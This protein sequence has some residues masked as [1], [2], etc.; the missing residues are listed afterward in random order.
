MRVCVLCPF[1]SSTR[2]FMSF[3][4][5]TEAGWPKDMPREALLP[6]VAEVVERRKE[7]KQK[8]RKAFVD[9][10]A[11]VLQAMRLTSR[12]RKPGWRTVKEKLR[13]QSC[14]RDIVSETERFDLYEE[15]LDVSG[16]WHAPSSRQADASPPRGRYR[17][18]P[19][20][21]REDRTTS[22]KRPRVGKQQL[23][24]VLKDQAKQDL[25]ML[26][27]E[28]LKNPFTLTGQAALESLRSDPRYEPINKELRFPE[29]LQVYREFVQTLEKERLD[30]FERELSQSPNIPGPQVTFEQASEIMGWKLDKR[31][32]GLSQEAIETRFTKWR[33]TELEECKHAFCAFL[34]ASPS[35]S[36]QVPERGPEFRELMQ[37]LSTDERYR[38]LDG[39]P[40][41][42]EQLVIERLRELQ[43]ES[44]KLGLMRV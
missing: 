12:D 8:Q 5:G 3:R 26:L 43:K 20:P 6:L 10:A 23:L 1:H 29:Q 41:I 25:T 13:E 14:Y 19:S 37:E 15:A 16:I 34:Q 36:A 4:Y 21:R 33:R 35:V 9:A 2:H 11:Q 7:E 27:T 40:A 22:P 28:R 17:R 31:F 32:M 18:P 24:R 39:Y 44:G 42:R 30:L 38:R